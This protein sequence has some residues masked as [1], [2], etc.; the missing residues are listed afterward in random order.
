MAFSRGLYCRAGG[1]GEV[2]QFTIHNSQFKIECKDNGNDC[3]FSGSAVL[4]DVNRMKI[5]CKLLIINGNSL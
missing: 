4:N 2:D 3:L 1:E 5:F